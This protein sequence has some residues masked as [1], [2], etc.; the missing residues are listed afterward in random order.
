MESLVQEVQDLKVTAEEEHKG[1]EEVAEEEVET[2]E[3]KT[4]RI[5]NST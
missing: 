5:Y 4:M 1:E 2:E 3:S